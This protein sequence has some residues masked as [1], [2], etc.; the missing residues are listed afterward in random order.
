MEFK[1][2]LTFE[3]D[4]DNYKKANKAMNKAIESFFDTIRAQGI[5]VKIID[6]EV[7]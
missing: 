5:E 6:I 1:T 4:I 2:Y 7:K 3:L